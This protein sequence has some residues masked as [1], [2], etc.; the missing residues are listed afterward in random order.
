MLLSRFWYVVLAL[1]LGGA[2]FTMFTAAQMYNHAGSRAMSDALTADSSAVDWYLRDDS[3]KRSSELIPITLNPDLAAGLAKAS[4]AAD[5]KGVREVRD[6]VRTALK[7]SE[8][9]IPADMKFDALWAVDANGRVI[10]AVGFEH[11]EDWELGGFAVVADALHGW[12]RDDAWIW[13]GRIYRVVAR[14]VEEKAGGEPV[15]A[16]VGAKIVDDNFA[17]SVSHRTGAAVG[18]YADGVRVA[19][20]APEGFDKAN[21][22]LITQDLKHLE[23]NKD[24][25][26]K[27]RSE[28]RVIGEHL[29]VVYARLPGEAWDLGAGYAVGRLA[30]SVGSPFDFVTQADVTD[31]QKVPTG[32]VALIA[33]VA[34]LAGLV[35]TFFEHTRPIQVFRREVTRLAKGEIDA[36]QPSRFSGPYKKLA[37]D[38]NDG[39][40]KVAAKGGVPRKA[41]DL[42]SVLGPLPAQPQMSAFSVP[43][44]PEGAAPSSEARP[45]LPKP[46]PSGRGAPR[47]RQSQGGVRGPE[48]LEDAEPISISGISVSGISG[49]HGPV[50]G[51]SGPHRAP[52]PP[53]RR[54]SG[55]MAAAGGEVSGAG[56]AP[57]DGFDENA[58]WQRVY[59]EF[60]ATKKQCGEPTANLTFEKFKGTLQRNK[61]AL[62]A[63]HA[64]ARVKFTVYV[65]E[66]KAALKASPVK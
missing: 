33:L 55:E 13:N 9:K 2:A 61:D 5:E 11:Q 21:L 35:F 41:A 58:D 30:V 1:A 48:G 28:V 26:E 59:E 53:P 3:R 27:G 7:A 8:A 54:S 49:V 15:G 45:Q 6:K 57:A 38:L 44:G 37:A 36:L 40:D 12:I 46:A 43:G 65:K 56:P 47:L 51:G 20:G 14:P 18:F 50:A 63:R 24:Y 16:L 42:E 23:T 31:K 34:A 4:A 22:D 25:K 29:G 52:P 17:R 62:V 66:G 60:L 32:L 39:I 64:C 10:A 19:S